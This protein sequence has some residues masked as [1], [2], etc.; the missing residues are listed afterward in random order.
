MCVSLALELYI[1]CRQNEE[2]EE[3]LF[4]LTYFTREIHVCIIQ[5]PVAALND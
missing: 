1:S 3:K 4:F 2:K 5:N